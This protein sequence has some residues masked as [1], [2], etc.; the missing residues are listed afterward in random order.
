MTNGQTRQI[1]PITWPG[2]AGCKWSAHKHAA[3]Y[4][5]LRV[6]DR[7]RDSA[8]LCPERILQISQEYASRSALFVPLTDMGTFS[9]RLFLSMYDVCNGLD[10]LGACV[11]VKP[12]IHPFRIIQSRSKTRVF[13]HSPTRSSH[14]DIRNHFDPTTYL[15]AHLAATE[16]PTGS[17]ISSGLVPKP[18]RSL[19]HPHT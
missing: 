3:P 19:G 1:D 7:S 13:R 4:H 16:T 17:S 12:S 5:P 9:V 15:N 14:I 6:L 10:F 18:K 11:A 8:A 2:N